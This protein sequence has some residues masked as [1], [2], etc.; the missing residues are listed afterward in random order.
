MRGVQKV[1]RMRCWRRA[2]AGSAAE[3]RRPDSASRCL[4]VAPAQQA[5]PAHTRLV[6]HQDVSE[7]ILQRC[8]GLAS[9]GLC[10]KP[11]C[12]RHKALHETSS[13]RRNPHILA[14]C[15]AVRWGCHVVSEIMRLE[16]SCISDI[17][18]M[19]CGHSCRA[20]VS[21]PAQCLSL[22]QNCVSLSSGVGRH[23]SI[24]LPQV[25]CSSR[26]CSPRTHCTLHHI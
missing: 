12:A 10:A 18:D 4:Y 11:S 22:N 5:E 24:A 23:E 9:A 26:S 16:C 8:F 21:A 13:M 1:A 19:S 20:C 17:S 6:G 14:A 7:D 3:T 25:V 15:T 2:S